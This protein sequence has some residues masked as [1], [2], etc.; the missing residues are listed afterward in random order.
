MTPIHA[1]KTK[2][3]NEP[4]R[5]VRRNKRKQSG[6]QNSDRNEMGEKSQKELE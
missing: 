1:L 4:K 6:V 5:V 3:S 2:P